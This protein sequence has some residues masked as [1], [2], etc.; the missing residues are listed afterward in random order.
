VT[1]GTPVRIIHQPIKLGTRSGQFFLEAHNQ[2]KDPFDIPWPYESPTLE[3]VFNM[4]SSVGIS[5]DSYEPDDVADIW[6]R[7]DGVPR[8]IE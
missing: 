8:E 2:D 4:I 6:R 7:G 1:V 5:T 3:D